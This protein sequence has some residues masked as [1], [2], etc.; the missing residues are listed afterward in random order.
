MNERSLTL[1]VETSSIEYGVALWTGGGVLAHR[2]VRR[3]D[4]SFRGI[5]ALVS[6]VLEPTGRQVTDVERIAVDAG[7]GNLSSVRAGVAYA[8]GLAFSLGVPIV[9]AN[10]LRLLALT[11]GQP[12]DQAVLCLRHA[13][14]VSAYA[15]LF[16]DGA[17]VA[18]RQGPLATLVPDLLAPLVAGGLTA[19]AV[20]GTFRTDVKALLPDLDVRDTGVAV[21]PV[22]ALCELVTAGVDPADLVEVA[23]PL[24]DAS[25]V[26]R[27][28]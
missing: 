17:A 18:M 12:T 24:T 8:N 27:A 5:G 20:A 7:P 2:T 21:P 13:G 28:R 6:A 9:S 14:G 1:A 4:P 26:F 3:D 10:S 25:P 11:A 16:R 19:V 22:L 15:G 23:S